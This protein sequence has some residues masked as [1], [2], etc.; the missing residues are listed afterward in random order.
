MKGIKAMA[1]IATTKAFRPLYDGMISADVYV[2]NEKIAAPGDVVEIGDVQQGQRTIARL[3]GNLYWI[4]NNAWT[5][6]ADDSNAT[7]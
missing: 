7:R 3:N 2:G 5:V 4:E 6:A 1:K